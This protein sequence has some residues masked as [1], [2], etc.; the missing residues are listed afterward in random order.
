M[1]ASLGVEVLE[2]LD[3]T[4]TTAPAFLIHSHRWCGELGDWGTNGL[5]S[6]RLFTT[7]DVYTYNSLHYFSDASFFSALDI[8]LGPT[9]LKKV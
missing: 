6:G 1:S 7:S 5:E 9:G 3:E 4:A 8:L 2:F